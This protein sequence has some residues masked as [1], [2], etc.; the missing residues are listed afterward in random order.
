MRVGESGRF[1]PVLAEK[2]RIA[3]D[4]RTLLLT[5]RSNV[6]F[7]DGSPF[8]ADTVSR[9]LPEGLRS[10][11]GSL[12]ENVE[13]V[14]ALDKRTVK[15]TFRRASPLLQEMLE[16]VMRKPGVAM[17]GTGPFV[18]DQ[19]S[20]TA[21]HANR[22][23]Y[24]GSPRI[25][26]VQ[27]ANFP[28]TRTA[29]AEL[30]RNRIDMLWEVGPDAL[31]SLTSSTTVSL[32]TYV[33][34]YQYILAFNTEAPSLRSSAIRRALNM[35][36]NRDALVARALNGHAI[37]SS[38]P[39]WPRY[40]AL[41]TQPSPMEFDPARAAQ[42]INAVRHGAGPILRF[43]CLT[44]TDA[45]YEL[46]ALELKRQLQP[47]GVEMDVRALAANELFEAE[48]AKKF[49]AVLINTISGPT[50]LRV[51]YAWH[52]RSE[53]NQGG[54]GNATVDR[55]FDRVLGAENETAY[56]QAVNDLEQAFKDDPPAMF[57]AWEQRARAVSK[58]FAVPA[59]EPGRD[60]MTTLRLWSPRNNDARLASRN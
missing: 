16:V 23:Y 56:R 17:V 57:L 41:G 9:I 48:R 28:T 1:E 60:V 42:M 10:F 30:L 29:W 58:R 32:F 5:L 24:F 44:L 11:W 31:D 43:T 6:K 15:I 40:W 47:V 38:G 20:T 37:S 55:A 14:T 34:H 53:G 36:V 13:S 19:N 12:V 2:W 25:S 52:S 54:F 45:P 4:R 33:R 18:V 21:F 51:Y 59:P 46:M 8:D 39:V 7:H 35:A 50:L 27:V 49:D 22:D 3:D 26:E